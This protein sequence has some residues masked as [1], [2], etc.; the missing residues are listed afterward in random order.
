MLDPPLSKY[1]HSCLYFIKISIGFHL[2]NNESEGAIRIFEN[3]T[4]IHRKF[5]KITSVLVTKRLG[6]A[7]IRAPNNST[8]VFVFH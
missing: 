8:W 3:H 1:I 6:F 7:F 2:K 4:V 5:L